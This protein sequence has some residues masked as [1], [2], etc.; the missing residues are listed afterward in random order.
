M[1][2]YLCNIKSEKRVISL[3]NT[4]SNLKAKITSERE[5][6]APLFTSERE[7]NTP[8]SGICDSTRKNHTPSRKNQNLDV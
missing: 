8:S 6:N 4:Q 1:L 7:N 2:P 3:F 5:N